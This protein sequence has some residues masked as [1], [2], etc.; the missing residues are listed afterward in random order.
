[1]IHGGSLSFAMICGT[2]KIAS[3]SSM[4]VDSIPVS[5]LGQRGAGFLA[6]H[7]DV[8][9]L[10]IIAYAAIASSAKASKLSL[11]AFMFI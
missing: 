5:K 10:T 9:R 2:N 11:F 3:L 7:G 1:M 8:L 6:A 4:T